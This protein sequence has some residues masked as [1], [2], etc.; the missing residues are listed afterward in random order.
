MTEHENHAVTADSRA[1]GIGLRDCLA[2]GLPAVCLGAIGT[3]YYVF[4]PKFYSDVVG[5][6]L[7]FLSLV[8]LLSR[9]WDAVTDPLAGQLSD[10]TRSPWGRRRPWLLA[11]GF[12]GCLQPSGRLAPRRGRLVVCG[13]DLPAV[14]VL[15]RG[16]GAL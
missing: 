16:G 6:P 3:T 14:P 15:D 13:H 12:C 7:G 5:V 10:R 4:L 1:A 8:V 9:L 2:Y 11:G